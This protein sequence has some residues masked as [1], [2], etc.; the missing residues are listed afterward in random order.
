M[1]GTAVDPRITWTVGYMQ[2]HLA[3][4]IGVAEL[5]ALVNLS[6]SRFRHLFG[7]QTGLG[8]GQYLQ[9]LR[10]RRARLLIERTFL[11]VKEVMALVGYNDPS[12]FSKDFRRYHGLSPS[13][14]RGRGVATPLPRAPGAS[15]DPPLVRRIRQPRAREPGLGWR[16][17]RL[18]L[19]AD[20]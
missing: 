16:S 8:P 17:N 6:P 4:P 12:H 2:R 18:S 10:L 11:S 19:I 1:K 5:A 7:A 3:E 14:L 13:A 9:R 15:V 20:R